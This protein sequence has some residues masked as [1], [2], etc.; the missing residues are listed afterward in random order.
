MPHYGCDFPEGPLKQINS[1]FHYELSPI[2]EG[3]WGQIESFA[4]TFSDESE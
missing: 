4:W 2:I 3:G 1:N